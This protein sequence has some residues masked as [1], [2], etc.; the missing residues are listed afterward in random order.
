M[1]LAW[2]PHCL[3]RLGCLAWR[4]AGPLV[5]AAAVTGAMAQ[6][7]AQP[8]A[9]VVASSALRA[10]SAPSAPNWN[11]LTPEQRQ[12]L[13]PLSRTWDQLTEPH[14]RKWIAL[15]ANFSR[16]PPAEQAKMHS[17]M[18]EWASLSARQRS[19]ARLNFG[20][21]QQLSADEKRAKWEAYQALTPEER[22]KLAEG[23]ARKPP[24][25]AA[26]IKPV[27]HSK[28]ATVPRPSP[29]ESKPPRI[30]VVPPG[31]STPPTH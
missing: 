13:S 9:A 14:R 23:A 21:A 7:P 17:R 26:A 22:R 15:A 5:A 1:F 31:E 25:T 30:V 10:V 2:T 28:L 3:R 27:P 4:L 24:A 20:E 29:D 11:Q 12:A 8:S 16:L 18:A 6:S 19:Q